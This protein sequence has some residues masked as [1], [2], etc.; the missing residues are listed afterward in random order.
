MPCKFRLF[1]ALVIFAFSRRGQ[2]I[3]RHGVS[4]HSHFHK[5]TRKK[6]TKKT[7]NYSSICTPV[8]HLVMFLSCEPF[9]IQKKKKKF[10]NNAILFS[11]PIITHIH[12]QVKKKLTVRVKT[13][14]KR[15]WQDEAGSCWRTVRDKK[16][17]AAAATVEDKPTKAVWKG[18]H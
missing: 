10:G 12:T 13:R 3:I 11:P 14:C 4:P 15:T 6:N 8:L 18:I 9:R 7:A 16:M 5:E 17:P 2:R 1:L